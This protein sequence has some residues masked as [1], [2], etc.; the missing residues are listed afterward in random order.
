VFPNVIK[1][2]QEE[3]A[4]RGVPEIGVLVLSDPRF[5]HSEFGLSTEIIKEY[6]S[7]IQ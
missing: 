4:I 7:L 6:D 2:L 1:K 3:R 5:Y